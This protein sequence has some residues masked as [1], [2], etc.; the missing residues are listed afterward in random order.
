MSR[1]SAVHRFIAPAAPASRLALVR[2]A[3]LLFAC[4]WLAAVG[5]GLVARAHLPA[6]R[7]MPVGLATLSG[8]VS[9]SVTTGVLV[10]VILLGL[11]AAAGRGYRLTAPLFAIGL[12]WLLSYRNSWGHMSHAEHLLTLHVAI[13]AAAPAGDVLRLGASS[14]SAADGPDARYGWPLRLCA[15]VTVSTYTIAGLTKLQL[16]GWAWLLG[17]ALQQ[18]IAHEALRMRMVG[19][20]AGLGAA[21]IPYPAVLTMMAVATVGLELGSGLALV[22]GMLRRG[23]VAGLW[24]MHVGIFMVMGIGFAYPLSGVAFVSLFEVE[25]WRRP[26]RTRGTPAASARP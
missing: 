3:V 6:E 22:P 18:Q 2:I 8:V 23:W 24:S 9:S 20:S 5:P 12:A 1:L 15:L 19:A 11:T 13:L 21:L 17:D 16:G 10:A 25:R 4:G 14:S 26:A 7:F